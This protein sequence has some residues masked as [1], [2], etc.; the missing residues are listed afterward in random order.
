L[1]SDGTWNYSYDDEGNLSSKTKISTGEV[2]S[3]FW[4]NRNELVKVEHKASST[5]AVDLRV[6]FGYDALGNL[7]AKIVDADGDGSG[8]AV[9]VKYALDGWKTGPQHSFVGNENWDV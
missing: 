3:Y 8:D 7:I 9:V 4:D 2:W 1:L 5:S 6:E